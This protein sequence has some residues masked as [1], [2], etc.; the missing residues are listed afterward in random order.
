M[1]TMNNSLP[2]A[3]K[4]WVETQVKGG[5]FTNASDY[6][7]DL[8]RRDQDAQDKR[9]RL[10]MALIEGEDSGVSAKSVPKIWNDLMQELSG[11]RT[12]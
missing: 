4:K 5:R 7:R 10:V 2:E 9:E 6:V 1:A 8:I 11:P 3:M 12:D